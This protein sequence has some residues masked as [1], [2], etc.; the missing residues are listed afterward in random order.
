MTHIYIYIQY[1]QN[2]LEASHL[3]ACTLKMYLVCTPAPPN[4]SA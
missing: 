2:I 4:T 1:I 3:I